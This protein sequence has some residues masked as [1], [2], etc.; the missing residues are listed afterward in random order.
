[1]SYVVEEAGIQ[2]NRKEEMKYMK[3]KVAKKPMKGAKPKAKAAAAKA[4]KAYSKGK[5]R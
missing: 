2:N 1:M 5:K 3:A 4:R